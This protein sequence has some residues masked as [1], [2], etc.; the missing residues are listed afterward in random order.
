MTIIQLIDHIID[1]GGM[2]YYND[3]ERFTIYKGFKIGEQKGILHLP[4]NK[5]LDFSQIEYILQ[6]GKKA[7]QQF[8][9]DFRKKR[10]E[11]ICTMIKH[12]QNR[13]LV[14]KNKKLKELIDV[15]KEEKERY[16]IPC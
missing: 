8:R 3:I 16:G 6:F 5:Q 11:H 2:E 12:C 14:S 1:T 10:Y 7:I 4:T 9:E 15:F 13:Y